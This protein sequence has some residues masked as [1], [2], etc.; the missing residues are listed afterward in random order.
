MAMT[1]PWKVA[2]ALATCTADKL[3]DLSDPVCELPVI[4]SAHPTPAD[5]CDCEC[6]GGHGQ[7]WVR[8]AQ[9]TP[10]PR[11][12]KL[13]HNSSCSGG[14]DATIEIGVH[15]CAPT[16]D[17]T[18]H[19]PTR[20]SVAEQEAYAKARMKDMRALMAAWTCCDALQSADVTGELMQIVPTG[21]QGGCGGVV[22]TGRLRLTGCP[23]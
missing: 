14:Y 11:P 12:A 19:P 8:Y 4:W 5:V 21:P 7:G 15:R 20:P 3:L 9:L 1:G 17:T 10:M 18:T 23:C 6:D 16:L 2:S 13:A 22:L